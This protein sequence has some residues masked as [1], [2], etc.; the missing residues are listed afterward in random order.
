[1]PLSK[2]LFYLMRAS[3]LL[4]A[5]DEG[6]AREVGIDLNE[7][8]DVGSQTSNDYLFSR[9]EIEAKIY[10]YLDNLSEDEVLKIEAIMYSGRDDDNNIVSLIK[11]LKSFDDSKETMISVIM[12]KRTNWTLY[13]SKGACNV[14]EQGRDI[15]TL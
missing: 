14:F 8:L 10:E 11:Y 15:D 4:D 3:F 7:G 6:I 12:S 9:R 5:E 1:M 2:H 13:F